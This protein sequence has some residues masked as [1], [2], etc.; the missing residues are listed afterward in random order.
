MNSAYSRFSG[1]VIFTSRILMA[2]L[3]T[4]GTIMPFGRIVRASDAPTVLPTEVFIFLPLDGVIGAA[5]EKAMVATDNNV[6]DYG[7][8]DTGYAAAKTLPI[9]PVKATLAVAKPASAQAAALPAPID[10]AIMVLEG[11]AS[12]YSRAGCLGCNPMRIM[13]NGQ[14]L[15]DNALTMAIGADKVRM[16]GR[17]AR[18]TNLATGLATTVLIT[19]TGGFYQ[20]KYGNRVADLTIATKQAIGMKGGLG[21]VR[22]EVF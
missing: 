17:K 9:T 15:N 4:A 13:A 19:D 20:S 6:P 7:Y 10:K 14:A 18:V 2:A 12:Y 22:V 21:R 3:I 5:A 8:S 11:V 16:V 1:V